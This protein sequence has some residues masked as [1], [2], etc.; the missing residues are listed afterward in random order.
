MN[1][2]NLYFS[3]TGNTEKVALRIEKTIRDLESALNE[4]YLDLN[5][6][7]LHLHPPPLSF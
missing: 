1:I 4:P 5:H 6:F 2:L 7:S 3:S